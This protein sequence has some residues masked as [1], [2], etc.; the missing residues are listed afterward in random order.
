MSES[1]LLS[2][3]VIKK[4]NELEI[5]DCPVA[6]SINHNI[7]IC[8]SSVVKFGKAASVSKEEENE[9]DEETDSDDECVRAG[10][11]PSVSTGVE[12]RLDV[13]GSS[14]VERNLVLTEGLKGMRKEGKK[15][16]NENENENDNIDSDDDSFYES[17]DTDSDDEIENYHTTES[18]GIES[19]KIE[20][21]GNI[22]NEDFFAEYEVN[23]ISRRKLK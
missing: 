18:K 5:H 9:E 12:V 8:S 15:N 17:S 6:A 20:E 4:M 23:K 14:Y 3:D 13:N 7:G 1:D 21:N 16:E 19:E 2:A 10:E 22:E 11:E